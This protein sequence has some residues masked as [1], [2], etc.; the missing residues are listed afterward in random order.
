MNSPAHPVKRG[1]RTRFPVGA[2]VGHALAA[3]AEFVLIDLVDG[4]IDETAL[5]ATAVLVAAARAEL[6]VRTDD[7]DVADRCLRLGAHRVVGALPAPAVEPARIAVVSDPA[8]VPAAEFAALDLR[9]LQRAALARWQSGAMSVGPPPLVL[10]AGQLGD[11][12]IWDEVAADLTPVTSCI[13][14]RIDLDDSIQGMAA[15]VLAAAPARFALVGH[16]LGGIVA[17]QICRTAP[18]RVTRVALLNCS[19]RAASSQQ[20]DAWAGLLRRLDAGDFDAVVDE[21]ADAQSPNRRSRP[22][23]TAGT[24]APDGPPGRRRRTAPSTAGADHPTRPAAVTAHHRHPRP[25]GQ[26]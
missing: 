25:G 24:V 14:L 23:Q 2:D 8:A 26:R 18:E 12:S 22:G 15:S 19:G 17:L 13:A 16:S 5:A 4:P 7:P 20:I 3:G 11:V 1:V 9:E 6:W 10:L 21:L